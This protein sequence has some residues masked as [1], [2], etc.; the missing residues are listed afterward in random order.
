MLPEVD[1]RVVL[2]QILHSSQLFLSKHSS[3][4]I[5]SDQLSRTSQLNVLWY[6]S[7]KEAVSST[8]SLLSPG[9]RVTNVGKCAWLSH[10]SCTRLLISVNVASSCTLSLTLERS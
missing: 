1:I 10:L 5:H 3:L 8:K 7:M 4:W 9:P 2:P 6:T